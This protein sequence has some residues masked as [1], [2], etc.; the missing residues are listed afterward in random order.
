MKVI[1][2][3]IHSTNSFDGKSSVEEMCQKAVEIGN[4]EICFTEHFSV[5]PRDVS[6]GVL[7][8]EQY[9]N[10]IKKAQK[11]FGKRL[12]IKFGLE[13]GEPH[14]EEYVDDL[15]FQISKMNLDFII[16]SVHNINGVKLR[17]FMQDKEKYDVYYEYF[18]EIYKMV[19]VSNI[20]VIGHMDL[21]KRYAYEKFGNYNFEDYKEIIE[22]IL[23]K[24]I[25]RGIGL[26]I[27]GS[28]Y[29]NSVGEPY[30][31][32]EV[33]K[34]YKELGGDIVTVGSDSHNYETLSKNN[35]K[36]LELLKEIGFKYVYIFDKR[37]KIKLDI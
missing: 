4:Y 17:L 2:Y 24:A 30:P 22:K 9:R 34:L 1:D 18:E 8:Y 19:S 28:G 14:L 21:M 25:S 36:M 29:L 35:K 31:K 33:L 12:N 23:K 16:G 10:D 26:E 32:K 3:H 37:E 5:D 20:D 7:N 6:Y 11:E 15:V 13:I 27:N